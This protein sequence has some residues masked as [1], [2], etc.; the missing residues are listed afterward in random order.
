MRRAPFLLIVLLASGC[1]KERRPAGPPPATSGPVL[2]T[3][4]GHTMTTAEFQKDVNEQSP[5]VRATTRTLEQK[6]QFVMVRI[7]DDLLEDE[8]LKAGFDKDAAVQNVC[9]GALIEQ[10]TRARF[11]DD[12]G[13]RSI[14]SASVHELYD[15][16]RDEYQRPERLRVQMIL[17]AG[18][19]RAEATH[20]RETLGKKRDAAAFAALARQR[21]DDAASRVRGGD[22]DFHSRDEL[23]KS[24]GEEVAQAADALLVPGDLSGVIHGTRGYTLLRLEARQPAVNQS[25]EEVEG[26]LRSRLWAA[27][28]GQ[29]YDDY[30]KQL[31]EKANVKVDEVQLARIDPNL[32]PGASSD[33]DNPDAPQ[34]PG[35]PA[36]TRP[37]IPDKDLHTPLSP[38][39]P[40]PPA[41]SSNPAQP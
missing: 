38:L 19:A 30:M 1:T 8:G 28:R 40:A 37:P 16:H 2:A 22:L 18:N 32:P 36:R 15:S 4:G 3:F 21:S 39:H 7:V 5:Y 9:Q 26:I 27:K 12:E 20:A 10:W 33:E 24:Y 29:L 35:G 23:A 31:L 41:K 17:F 14:S 25:F 13:M 34:G 6:R 11:N